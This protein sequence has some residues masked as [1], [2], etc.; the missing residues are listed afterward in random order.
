MSAA[1]QKVVHTQPSVRSMSPALR[2]RKQ[3]Q[4]FLS[5]ARC[6]PI[7]ATTLRVI[8]GTRDWVG[9]EHFPGHDPIFDNLNYRSELS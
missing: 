4:S 9:C 7:C 3:R 6:C 5:D 8:E 1:Y 2:R